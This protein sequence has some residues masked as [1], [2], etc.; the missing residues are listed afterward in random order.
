MKGDFLKRSQDIVEGFQQYFKDLYG[1]PTEIMGD[2]TVFL[3]NVTLPK[4]SQGHEQLLNAPIVEGEL[5]LAMQ[6]SD[7]HKAPGPDGFSMAFYKLLQ[8]QVKFP[9]LNLFNSVATQGPVPETFCIAKMIVLPKPG[10]NLENLGSYRPISLLNCD[11]K[12][13][14]KILANRLARVLP[15]LVAAPQ[16]GFVRGSLPCRPCAKGARRRKQNGDRGPSWT[17]AARA[18][19]HVRPQCSGERWGRSLH[20]SFLAVM[21]PAWDQ[22]DAMADLVEKSTEQETRSPAVSISPPISSPSTSEGDEAGGTEPKLQGDQICRVFIETATCPPVSLPPAN[23]PVISLAHRRPPG[24]CLHGISQGMPNTELMALHPIPSLVQLNVL[25]SPPLMLPGPLLS[26]HPFLNS[27]Y[28]GSSGTFSVFPNRFKRR[29][30]IYE[31]D[32]REGRQPQ[33]LARRVFT[34][35]R[36]RWRQQ[37]VNGAFADLRRLIPTHPPDKKLSKNEILRLAMRYITFLARLLEDQLMGEPGKAGDPCQR[38]P[39]CPPAAAASSPTSGSYSEA[40]SPDS[41]DGEQVHGTENGH[42][43]EGPALRA[44]R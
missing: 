26:S 17:A 29:P 39:E 38:T 40:V 43:V 35:S 20:F 28:L 4:V 14:A 19:S 7:I 32:V 44:H 22:G 24:K 41:E 42:R 36:E 37:N 1:E 5:I 27:T 31:P 18:T 30:S 21:Y 15:D 33:K 10:R 2:S 23:V 16:V 9:L 6:Q 13:H 12:L 25:P 34:N 8:E 3:D 11:A